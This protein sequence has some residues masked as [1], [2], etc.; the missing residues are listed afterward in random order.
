[1]LRAMYITRLIDPSSVRGFYLTYTDGKVVGA[2]DVIATMNSTALDHWHLA[3]AVHEVV[4]ER[5]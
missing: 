4:S 3:C 5:P 1:V 2:I